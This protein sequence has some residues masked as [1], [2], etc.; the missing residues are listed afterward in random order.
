L[1]VGDHFAL[2]AE[3]F[4][5]EMKRAAVVVIKAGGFCYLPF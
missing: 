5:Q 1:K 4:F 2:L 3:I